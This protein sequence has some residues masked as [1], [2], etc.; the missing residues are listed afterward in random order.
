MV[1]QSSSVPEAATASSSSSA[2][3]QPS[4]SGRGFN[5]Q[6]STFDDDA[7]HECSFYDWKWG[8]K[9]SFVRAGR[10]G[11]PVLLCHGFGVG[12][13]HFDRNIS[14]LAQ[15]HRVSLRRERQEHR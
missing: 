5:P 9:I 15:N 3:E 8:S 12:S 11:P 7:P 6:V 13:Y 4:T 1:A 10:S 2:A 14:V